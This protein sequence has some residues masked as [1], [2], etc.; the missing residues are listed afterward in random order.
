MLPNFGESCRHTVSHGLLP[1]AVQSLPED[2]GCFIRISA[3]RT[4]NGPVLRLLPWDLNIK[5]DLPSLDASGHR[6]GTGPA[7]ESSSQPW[8]HARPRSCSIQP[9]Q[10]ALKFL[11]HWNFFPMKTS[12]PAE[13]H[14]AEPSKQAP[15][16]LPFLAAQG[17]WLSFLDG[18]ELNKHCK[19]NKTMLMI[20]AQLLPIDLSLY[21]PLKLF[22]SQMKQDQAV[23]EEYQ[24][25]SYETFLEHFEKRPN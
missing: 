21:C 7:A 16:S 1:E 5:A 20:S 9:T 4:N 14:E 17:I 13:A 12:F 19:L 18:R 24:R 15:C 11:F 25:R 6:G 8:P 22:A 23:L 2:H 10:R 3:S